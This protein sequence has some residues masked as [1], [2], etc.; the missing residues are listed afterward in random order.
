MNK[1]AIENCSSLDSNVSLRR[2]RRA[3]DA[4]AINH[5]ARK[6]AAKSQNAAAQRRARQRT[7]DRMETAPARCFSFARE[8]ERAARESKCRE[9]RRATQRLARRESL[10]L[11]S[12]WHGL[13]ARAARAVRIITN[14][15]LES[16]RRPCVGFCSACTHAAE[17]WRKVPHSAFLR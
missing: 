1:C 14:R 15:Q 10:S 8:I 5:S 17:G 12:H 13:L 4:H 16:K 3:L 11:A 6:P 9:R 7:V 2:S